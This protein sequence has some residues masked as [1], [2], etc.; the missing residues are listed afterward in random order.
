MMDHQ[1]IESPNH[2]IRLSNQRINEST[3]QRINE[4]D[5]GTQKRGR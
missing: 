5:Y 3:N 4:L 2:R 1:I